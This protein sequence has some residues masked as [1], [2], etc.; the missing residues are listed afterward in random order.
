MAD[1]A[2]LAVGFGVLPLASI[3]LYPVR[4]P[5]LGR[6]GAVWG[7][8]VG[9]LAFLGLSHAM[10][11]VLETKPFL[12][13][14]EDLPAALFLMA[15]LGLGS[16]GAWFLFEGSL[17]RTEPA[18]VL[19]AAAIFLSLHSF[20]DGLVLGRDFV[21][22]FAPSV[23]I[24]PL[25]VSATVV[26]RFV[27]GVILLV[28]AIAARWKVPSVTLVLLVSIVSIP[29][30]YVPGG[31]A[32]AFGLVTGS[33]ATMA[34]SSFLAAAEAAFVLLVLLRGFVPLARADPG[35]RWFLWTALGFIGISAVHFFVE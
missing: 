24:S 8:L 4:D 21:G 30:A 34:L 28:P 13:G 18:K 16:L 9:V 6:R 20:G 33:G 1:L 22:G 7:G 27:E 15:G 31:L 5:I 32:D 19:A 12:F 35:K 25:S 11:H 29:A 17:L 2:V 10:A 26:H 14:G 23:P 3:I